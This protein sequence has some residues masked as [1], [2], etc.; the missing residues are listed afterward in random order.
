MFTYVYIY[1]HECEMFLNIENY[2]N[3]RYLVEIIKEVCEN[4]YIYIYVHIRIFD[5]LIYV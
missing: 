5:V 1:M 3:G 2:I 4:M